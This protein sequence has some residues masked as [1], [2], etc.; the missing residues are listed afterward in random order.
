[1]FEEA[2]KHDP[3]LFEAQMNFGHVTLSFRGYQDA[4]DAFSKALA[5]HPN[6][7]EALIA[8][9]T[10]ARGLKRFDE[11]E[12]R[13]TDASNAEPKRPEAY[14]NLGVLHQDYLSGSVDDLKKAQAFFNQF[15]D[16]AGG[17]DQY[18][19]AVDG[20]KRRCAPQPK[21]SRVRSSCRPG[22]L[23]NIE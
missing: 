5:I 4:Y 17:S 20:V 18:K 23:Q 13:Y 6:N 10:A 14:F 8:R 12:N 1:F 11:A 19:E 15:V 21:K 9:G 22:R 7:Y 2:I 16:R 3:Q